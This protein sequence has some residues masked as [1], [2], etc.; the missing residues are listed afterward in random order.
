MRVLL[1]VQTGDARPKSI[2]GNRRLDGEALNGRWDS[3]AI[4]RAMQEL[5]IT[6][7]VSAI[8]AD[9]WWLVECENAD[10]GRAAI[11][12]Y[13][14]GTGCTAGRVFRFDHCRSGRHP[15]RILASGGRQCQ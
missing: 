13:E 6:E 1:F 5:A 14:G 8:G 2:G 10:A 15:G 7:E 3:R 11:E 4:A 12:C 9:R